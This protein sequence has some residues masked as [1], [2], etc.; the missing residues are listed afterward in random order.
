MTLNLRSLLLI[1]V[2][3]FSSLCFPVN[4]YSAETT[5]DV[6]SFA[7]LPVLHQ[8]RVKPM[9]SFAKA[10]IKPLTGSDRKALEHLIRIIFNPIKAEQTALIKVSHPDTIDFLDLPKRKNKRYSYLEIGQAMATKETIIRTMIN[11]PSVDLTSAQKELVHLYEQTLIMGDLLGSLSLFSPLS[12]LDWESRPPA[13]VPGKKPPYTASDFTKIRQDIHAKAKAIVTTKGTNLDDYTAQ[14]KNITSLAFALAQLEIPI[15]YSHLF[16]VISIEGDWLSPWDILRQEKSP[17]PTFDLWRDAMIAYQSEQW[18]QWNDIIK[19]LKNSQ[20]QSITLS[21]ENIYNT[22]DPFYL[23]TVF[24]LL[25]LVLLGFQTYQKKQ[26]LTLI[27]FS[28]FLLGVVFHAVGIGMRILILQRPPVSTLYES[29]LFV[30]LIITTYSALSFLK[31]RQATNL[32]AIG[33]ILGALLQLKAFFTDQS[34]D[35]FL[36]LSAVLNTNFWLATHVLCITAGYAFCLI[37]SGFA[38]YALIKPKKN[39]PFL[40]KNIQKSALMALLLCTLGTILG[41]VWAD[42][43]WGRFWGWDP[44]ENGALLIILWL[45][46]LLHGK[47]SKQVSPLLYTA[48][49][50]YLSVIV[51]L[52][53]FGV[54]LLSIGLHAYGFTDLALWWLIGFISVE[55]CFIAFY[56]R[57]SYAH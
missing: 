37:T 23:S 16:K 11:A 5:L 56:F 7:Y 45:V 8:G 24:Y 14:E 19:Q 36:M 52:S 49:L 46:W 43:S 55:T 17:P 22:L 4:G 13:F 26:N 12:S 30:G 31:N 25:T 32:L 10:V 21:I 48:G 1:L 40:E 29:I 15:L 9:E 53:W 47:I 39:S 50:A 51:A 6:S 57:K 33:S 27:A 18:G 41:G 38:H 44:K 28:I 54:N 2:L 3:I 20:P 42:Q 35:T 34:G